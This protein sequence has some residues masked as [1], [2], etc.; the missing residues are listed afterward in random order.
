MSPHPT[1]QHWKLW[2]LTLHL[3]RKIVSFQPNCFCLIIL[4][5]SKSFAPKSILSFFIDLDLLFCCLNSIFPICLFFIHIYSLTYTYLHTTELV[6]Y[7][8]AVFHS[9]DLITWGWYCTE[10]IIQITE[11]WRG[12]WLTNTWWTSHLSIGWPE[13]RSN[14]WTCYK[15]QRSAQYTHM[16]LWCCASGS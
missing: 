3:L 1:K 16:G 9:V 8:T 11:R 13:T 6:H 15:K 7:Y 2:A 4:K 10:I 14:T 5:I 12:C